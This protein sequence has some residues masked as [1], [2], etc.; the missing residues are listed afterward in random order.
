[1]TAVA[2]VVLPVAPQAEKVGTFVDW[3]GRVRPFQDALDSNAMSDH[4]VLDMLAA[5]LG[6][7]LE[8][9]TQEQ[10]HEQ[11]TGSVRGP[12][13]AASATARRVPDARTPDAQAGPCSRPG[14]PCSTRD[15]CRTASRS[16]RAPRHGRSL[17]CPRPTP[18]GSASSTGTG[19]GVERPGAVTVPVLVTD[20]MVDRVVWLPTNSVGCAVRTELRE[21]PARR[22]TLP[23]GRT[24][25]RHRP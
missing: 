14:R 22:S 23:A 4:R 6:Y 21:G 10:V 19:D 3:E 15:A 1:M 9:R 25:W 11:F 5:E 8:T 7:F 12:V 17:V 16:S 13:T 18:S 20:Q 24:E 2:D